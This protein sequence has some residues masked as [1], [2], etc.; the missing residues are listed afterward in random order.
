MHV[1]L[2]PC[3]KYL[4]PEHISLKSFNCDKNKD[5]DITISFHFFLRRLDVFS[6]LTVFSMF[7]LA[8]IKYKL[9]AVRVEYNSFAE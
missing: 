1:H 6:C 3:L 2:G 5:F 4:G 7:S 9:I 8:A